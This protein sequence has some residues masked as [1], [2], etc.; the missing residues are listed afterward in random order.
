MSNTT[1][2]VTQETAMAPIGVDHRPS[3][4]Y[5]GTSLFLPDVIRKKIG[6]A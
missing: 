6:V 5:P 4:K 3:V 2:K 1:M